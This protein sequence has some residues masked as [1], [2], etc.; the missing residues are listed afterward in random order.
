MSET[1]TQRTERWNSPGPRDSQGDLGEVSLAKLYG[2]AMSA[3]AT[4][5]GAATKRERKIKLAF[6]A[7]LLLVGTFDIVT[8]GVLAASLIRSGDSQRAAFGW[9]S[10][11]IIG[12]SQA[13]QVV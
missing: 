5:Y 9:T 6:V 12:F 3:G 4:L 2:A 7:S 8:D 13:C 11:G 1:K 10:L